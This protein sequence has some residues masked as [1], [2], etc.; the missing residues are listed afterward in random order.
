MSPGITSARA[1]ALIGGLLLTT[2]PADAAA[3]PPVTGF[4]PVIRYEVSGDV[5]E[6]V[7]ATPDGGTLVYSDS[8][9]EEI[10]FVDITPAATPT[11][12]VVAIGAIVTD[13]R[14]AVK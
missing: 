2:A 10:G 7:S 3:P 8:S 1:G 13:S 4:D 11:E 5:A 14:G 12:L 6:I 9:I